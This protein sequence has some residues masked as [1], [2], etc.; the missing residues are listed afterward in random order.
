[1]TREEATEAL[2]MLLRYEDDPVKYLALKMV[3]KALEQPEPCE[4]AITIDW[5]NNYMN[6]MIAGSD[7]WWGVKWMLED[8][9]RWKEG[10]E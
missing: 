6:K 5:L 4:D 10:R 8:W 9:M 3:I 1:M 7:R 2:L